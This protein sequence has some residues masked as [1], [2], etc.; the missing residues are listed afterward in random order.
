LNATG[1][2][3]NS[4]LPSAFYVA[5]IRNASAAN[6]L[7]Y[8]T[9][10]DE[11]VYEGAATVETINMS[12]FGQ[13]VKLNSIPYSS[14]Q[15]ITTSNITAKLDNWV[16]NAQTYT[17]GPTVQARYVACG[18]ISGG[19]PHALY[20][21]DG[22]NWFASPNG[23]IF[24]T[25]IGTCAAYNGN[26]WVLGGS[27][28]SGSLY[29]S[30]DGIRWLQGS[31]TGSVS[32]FGVDWGNDK[33]VAISQ[34]NIYYSYD[35]INW[36]PSANNIFTTSGVGQAVAFNGI[37]WV[38]VGTNFATTSPPSITL[39]YSADGITW[40]AANTNSFGATVGV[41]RGYGVAWNGIRW[42]AVGTNATSSS[43]TVVYSSDGINWTQVT[44][45]TT[46]NGAG[47][48][49]RAVAWNG[50]RFV[51]V[52]TNIANGPNVT[53]ITSIDGITW[54]ATTTNIFTSALNA[55]G[56]S[57]IWT[58]TKWIAGGQNA[59]G[60]NNMLYSFDGL[61]W[62][63][64]VTS[65]YNAAS[66]SCYGIA[67]NSVRPNQITFPRNI[68][69]AT[70][71][72]LT[73][74]PGLLSTNIYSIDGGLTWVA[75]TSIFGTTSSST[76]GGYC[77]AYNGKIWLAGGTNATTPTVTLA[78]SFDG[79]VWTAV[80]NFTTNIMGNLSGGVCR[81]IAWSP[82]LNIWVAVGR[83]S[84]TTPTNGSF[85]LAYSYDGINW[86]G[87]PS[88]IFAG[89]IGICVTWGK[90][91]F[92]A[93]GGN[94]SGGNKIYYST[95]GINW[96][97]NSGVFSTG[98]LGIGFNGS[99]WVAVGN[100]S[101]STGVA[102]SYNGI[103]WSLG[104][105]TIF[106]SGTQINSA[107]AWSGSSNRWVATG[108][109]TTNSI[110]YSFDGINWSASTGA[111]AL[112]GSSGIYS[113]TWAGN[114]FVAGGG[115]VGTLAQYT[116]PDGINWTPNGSTTM[117]SCLG[118]AWSS[119]Q[120]NTEQQLLNV[121]IQQPTLALGAGTNT[122]AYSYDGIKWRGL[123]A[124]TFASS[125]QSACWNGKLWVAGGISLGVGII[126]Y[127]FDG[128]NWTT[129]TQSILN[130][131]VYSI[132]W[133]GTVFVAVGQGTTYVMAYSYDGIN[134]IASAT[135]SSVAMTLARNVTWGQNYFV[136]V[137]NTGTFTV[138][139]GFAA[140]GTTLTVTVVSGGT[141][142]VGQLLTLTG[143][144]AVA[145]TYITGQLTGTAGGIGTYSVNNSNPIGVSST[146]ATYGFYNAATFTG[147]ISI[148]TLTVSAV[149]GTI[150]IGQLV[151]GGTVSANTYITAGSG[152]SWTVSI[153]QTATAT[154]SAG[155]GAAYSTDGINWTAI[156]SAYVYYGS[157][158][159]SNGYNSVI[160][161]D[162]RW[163][164]YSSNA[165]N[166]TYIL[167][168][169]SLTASNPWIFFGFTTSQSSSFGITYGF[170]PVSSSPSGTL[171][172]TVLIIGIA[173]QAGSGF[174]YSTNGGSSWT[175]NVAGPTPY[176][177]C[178]AWNGKRFLAGFTSSLDIKYSTN[179]TGN[180]GIV[181][182]TS[183]SITNP[184]AAQLFT[185]INSFGVSNWPTLGSVYVDSA[186]TLSSTSGLN[187]NNQLDIYS[188][189]YFNN[190][191]NNMAAT[192]KATQ[193][194]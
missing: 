89:N 114:R 98:Y 21:S 177:N 18:G 143:V 26:I 49:G 112:S 101:T 96:I 171:Y 77:V 1:A 79:I 78:Y 141:L 2:V 104:A 76:I 181:T 9:T 161:A 110:Y 25:G 17:F 194:P 36:L 144:G 6:S 41:S 172:G 97:A 103:N 44:G 170:Y 109:S 187:T 30:Y 120:V 149:T 160:F 138:T 55:T 191:Y 81:G 183:P 184:T 35:G 67:Y 164:I 10:T 50:S 63:P 125:G 192:I 188:D 122:I 146:T 111:P 73:P 31:L 29:Y 47:G 159:I 142:A 186:V 87:V 150:S 152:L 151:Y 22:I 33:F 15:Q 75:G 148:T 46:F 113:V 11:I 115:S 90:D 72:Y 145:G 23:N 118:L 166:G 70:G 16:D 58:G 14:N 127:S 68:V 169:N 85:Q 51:A 193:I 61:S 37:R 139:G 88:V 178:I 130:I 126:A 24:S 133:N 94:T 28:S 40:T 154:G 74:G 134:W 180:S 7:Y 129:A 137:G 5:P 3:L 136:A 167:Y 106:N 42:V 131:A 121:A 52:G 157:N 162:N 179:T 38:A 155:G 8:N 39:A 158:Y 91:K 66:A 13:T 60:N 19:S 65:P 132:A 69:V 100:N 54:A 175:N 124:T 105:T 140:T 48:I 174:S 119:N 32:F 153:S 117:T 83:G 156:T 64:V 57:I 185:S 56:L 20:S 123:G 84:A 190:G 95:D 165:A 176:P 163:L 168:A 86:V 107:V 102:Y 147:S 173:F 4:Q 116:S 182:L 99:I 108:L 62:F 82:Q 27:G 128:I 80:N 12:N 92:V 71:G 93:G 59:T 43:V 135:R 53:C 189:T 34:V 45:G